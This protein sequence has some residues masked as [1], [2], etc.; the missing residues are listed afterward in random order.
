MHSVGWGF[1]DDD[2]EEENQRPVVQIMTGE[3]TNKE[4]V[5]EKISAGLQ[6][7][8]PSFS[9]LPGDEIKKHLQI[10]I[11]SSPN[12]QVLENSQP[13]NEFLT[14]YR[15]ENRKLG[16]FTGY[17]Y[18]KME[19]QMKK[20]ATDTNDTDTYDIH[21]YDAHFPVIPL[22][23]VLPSQSV[24]F[25][26]KLPELIPTEQLKKRC[27]IYTRD[28]QN[29][30]G[31]PMQYHECEQHLVPLMLRATLFPE[32]AKPA[33]TDLEENEQLRYEVYPSHQLGGFLTGKG[34]L[35][36]NEGGRFSPILV[37]IPK[38]SNLTPPFYRH[39]CNVD[40][41]V[42]K[43]K[44]QSEVNLCSFEEIFKVLES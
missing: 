11:P 3:K 22:H 41:A 25:H 7:K 19:I 10:A 34:G 29:F 44:D 8:L 31:I 42:C 15:A 39:P 2:E 32:K 9:Q 14:T 27:S 4:Q 18:A 23:C 33:M 37:D 38:F 1:T 12:M 5:L 21:T 35:I 24:R 26:R 16:C 36:Y 28:I 30:D 20:E 6:S 40:I 43:L 13:G 17:I